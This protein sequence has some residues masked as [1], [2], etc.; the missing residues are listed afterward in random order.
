MDEKVSE[1][2]KAADAWKAAP[3]HVRHMAG[4]Y[5]EPILATLL[6]YH[7]RIGI[8]EGAVFGVVK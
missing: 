6:D 1:V 7:V 4:P 3:A 5:V 8:L 2:K